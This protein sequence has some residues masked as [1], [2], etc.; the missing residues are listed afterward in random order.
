MTNPHKYL[1]GTISGVHLPEIEAMNRLQ[2]NGIIS[3]LCV[4]LDDIAPVDVVRA[5]EFLLENQTN[6]DRN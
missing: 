6:E 2:D 5:V 1:R 4:K 3:D